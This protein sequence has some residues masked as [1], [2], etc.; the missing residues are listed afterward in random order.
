MT[1]G[2]IVTFYCQHFQQI[3]TQSFLYAKKIETAVIISHDHYL[4]KKKMFLGDKFQFS[5]TFTDPL[6]R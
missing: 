1:E 3:L 6:C 2:E 5:A 4:K